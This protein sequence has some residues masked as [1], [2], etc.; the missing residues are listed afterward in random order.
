MFSIFDLISGIFSVLKTPKI[1]KIQN[2][3]NFELDFL[4]SNN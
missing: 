3:G 2:F 1:F 4:K